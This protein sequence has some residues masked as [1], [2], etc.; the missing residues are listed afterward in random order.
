M[1]NI[2]FTINV[3][4]SASFRQNTWK[5]IVKLSQIKNKRNCKN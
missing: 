5:S 1:R 4:Y 3:I 2:K